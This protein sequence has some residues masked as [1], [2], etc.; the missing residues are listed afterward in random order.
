MLCLGHHEGGLGRFPIQTTS[1]PQP[2]LSGTPRILAGVTEAEKVRQASTQASESNG[3][4]SGEIEPSE[5]TG[6]AHGDSAEA[7]EKAEAG[8][9]APGLSRS[10]LF[11]LE[12]SQVLAGMRPGLGY[13]RFQ[14]LSVRRYADMLR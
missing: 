9:R 12:T 8:F 7:S 10:T 6:A 5:K 14:R 2:R 4:L 13:G 11:R 3:L 1:W